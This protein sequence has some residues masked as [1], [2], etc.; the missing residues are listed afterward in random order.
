M[1][2]IVDLAPAVVKS[3]PV[4]AAGGDINEAV[5]ADDDNEDDAGRA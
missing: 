4:V 3:L 2:A 1:D 5:R